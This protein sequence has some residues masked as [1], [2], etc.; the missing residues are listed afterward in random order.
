MQRR[1]HSRLAAA[2]AEDNPST[3]DE[4]VAYL[5]W[6]DVYDQAFSLD[7]LVTRLQGSSRVYLLRGLSMIG[8]L[9]TNTGGRTGRPQRD[10]AGE[11][12]DGEARKRAIA[13]FDSGEIQ[14]LTHAD[15]ILQA[16]RLVLRHG[17]S[18]GTEDSSVFGPLI[19]VPR[20]K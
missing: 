2:T 11:I 16:T 12:L 8:T 15:S 5:S 17:G 20:W 3:L 19:E 7:A 18:D 14:V 10:L 9:I 13:M 4:A 1:A 6:S